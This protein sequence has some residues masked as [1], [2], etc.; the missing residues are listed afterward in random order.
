MEIV[1]AKNYI[2]KQDN[3]PTNLFFYINT[4]YLW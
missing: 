2:W 3:N 4:I 1:K